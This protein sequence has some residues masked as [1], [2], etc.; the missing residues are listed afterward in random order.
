MTPE[1]V[2]A[3]ISWFETNFVCFLGPR[4]GYFEIETGPSERFGPGSLCRY[5]EWSLTAPQ[6]T[7]EGATGVMI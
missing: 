4:S 5:W 3:L 1:T 2:P 6:A 7:A